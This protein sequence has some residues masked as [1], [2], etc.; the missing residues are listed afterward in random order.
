[1]R[2]YIFTTALLFISISFFAQGFKIDV[3][4]KNLANK[5]VILGH[6]FADELI[7]DDTI[8][9]NSKGFGTFKGKEKLPGG[10]YF[11]FLPNKRFFDFL[12]DKEQ[13]FSITGDTANFDN[14]I[15]FKGSEEN[16]RFQKYKKYLNKVGMQR[17][18]LFEEKKTVKNDKKKIA[19][20]DAQLK[21]IG[22]EAED[23]Y[24]KTTTEYPNDF[25]T[26]FLKATREPKVPESI[27]DRKEQ[28]FYFR[29]HYF[30]NFDVSDPR[31]LRTP[32]YKN[33]IDKFL[34]KVLMQHPDTLISEVDKLVEK[35]RTNEELFRFMLVHLF[36]KYASSQIMT[37]EN[38][39]VHIAEKYYI[40]EASW[41]APEFIKEL[42]NKVKYRKKCLI[43]TIR[44]NITFNEVPKDT[45]SINTL[46]K[47]IPKLEEDGTRIEASK[48]DSI[49]KY[50]LKVE[51]LK[52]YFDKFTVSN[53][54]NKIASKYTILWFWTPDCSHCVKETPE[55]YKLYQEK[56]LKK[57]G[58]EVVTVFLQKD[59][60]DWKSFSHITKEWLEFIKDNELNGWFNVWNPFDP[61]RKNYD[62]HSSPVLYVLD[63]NK[64]IIAKRLG[65]DQ[66]IEMIEALLK[67]EK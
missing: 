60:T 16:T 26:K 67:S 31:L 10:M 25:F 53:S 55:F 49:V 20:I 58:V 19:E 64:E 17:K 62:I 23:F 8:T 5:E 4:I 65:Y 56:A 22:K 9:L 21:K 61:F 54:L 41:S 44:Q 63:E 33:S 1:M 48:A 40:K 11:V 57:Q 29:N 14:S 32:I 46:L 47:M 42:K 66:A 37:A 51:L 50:N 18:K 39:Y 7:P 24:Q 52:E 6:H 59:I 13:T 35:S 12:L 36:N 43:G 3:H 30:D 45:N 34:D 2:K 28:Y 38:V 27:S 15:S